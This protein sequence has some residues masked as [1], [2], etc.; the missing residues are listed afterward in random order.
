VV[1][2]KEKSQPRAQEPDIKGMRAT[3]MDTKH[4]MRGTAAGI[5]GMAKDFHARNFKTSKEGG[6]SYA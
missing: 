6:E 3:Q 5:S 1:C 4:I 2:S